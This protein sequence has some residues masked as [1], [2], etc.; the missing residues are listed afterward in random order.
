MCEVMIVSIISVTLPIEIT[1]SESMSHVPY[2][3]Y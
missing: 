2:R 3:I 1:K